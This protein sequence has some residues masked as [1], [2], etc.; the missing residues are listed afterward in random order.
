MRAST[1]SWPGVAIL[2]GLLAVFFATLPIA[3]ASANTTTISGY[4]DQYNVVHWDTARWNTY[5]AN[6]VRMRP[7]N[8]GGGG[9]L[10]IGLRDSGG[11]QFAR[12]EGAGSAWLTIY[13][14]NGSSY[15]PYGQFWLNTKISNL[16]GGDGCGVMY[17]E[18]DFSWNVL[19]T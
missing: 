11:G 5:D 15:Q 13:R 10:A 2:A 6:V 8:P 19:L 17:W 3:S 12:G 7:Y 9:T 14:N 1:T 18:A 4:Q 16:C